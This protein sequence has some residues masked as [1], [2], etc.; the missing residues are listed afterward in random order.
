VSHQR[1]AEQRQFRGLEHHGYHDVVVRC[2]GYEREGGTMG[3]QRARGSVNAMILKEHDVRGPV[4]VLSD[5]VISRTAA[6][7]CSMGRATSPRLR[8]AIAV[9]PALLAESLLS[10]LPEEVEATIVVDASASGPFDL[11]VIAGE[12]P[13]IEAGMVLRLDDGPETGPTR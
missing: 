1:P 11:A 13:D 2:R 5:D 10:L 8:V 3:R 9:T 12:V 4:A 7:R 6:L